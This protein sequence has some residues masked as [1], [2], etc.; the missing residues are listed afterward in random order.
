MDKSIT[1]ALAD[2]SLNERNVSAFMRIKV[3]GLWSKSSQRNI[4]DK[5]GIVTI[6][7]PTE[8]QV[9]IKFF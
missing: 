6:W 9:I 4:Y 2:A 5:E 3:A 1:K 8:K 7:E